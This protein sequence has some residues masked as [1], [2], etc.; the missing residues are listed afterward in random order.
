MSDSINESLIARL[1]LAQMIHDIASISHSSLK[2]VVW[3]L[4]DK[5]ID[6]HCKCTV[7][8][9]FDIEFLLFKLAQRSFDLCY[10]H[11]F[12]SD[13]SSD[14]M[15]EGRA[16][17]SLGRSH[18]GLGRGRMS[19]GRGHMSIGR[20]QMSIGRGHASIGRG[21][22]SVGRGHMNVGRGLVKTWQKRYKIWQGAAYVFAEVAGSLVEAI[23][24]HWQRLNDHKE[25]P[26]EGRA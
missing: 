17:T 21:H 12:R 16:V 10:E 15:C 26:Q 18:L 24:E 9:N 20:G 5:P 13:G 1:E 6:F 7:K 2:T 19:I 4:I 25:W 8:K 22:T 11:L 23:E 14:S 3:L